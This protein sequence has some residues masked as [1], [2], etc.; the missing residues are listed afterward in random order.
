[1]ARL[2]ESL[3]QLEAAY[4][5]GRISSRL[6]VDQARQALFN[7]Q[8]SLLSARA[9]YDTRV[10]GYK[11]DLGLPPNLPLVIQRHPARP[12]QFTDA[13][14]T[15][16]D[17]QLG[18]VQAELRNPDRIKSVA[19]LRRQLHAL[20]NLERPLNRQLKTI[21]QD[22]VRLRESVPNRQ[23]Q[24]RLLGAREDLA[25]LSIEQARVDPEA[26]IARVK[27]LEKRIS[28][29]GQELEKE[30]G[31]LHAFDPEAPGLDLE[32]ARS[33][34]SEIASDLSG[35]LLALSLD[36]TA[37]RLETATLPPI[38]LTEEE[39]LAIAKEN[40][41]DLMNA[42]ARLVDAWR[43]VDYHANPLNSAVDLVADGNLNTIGDSST[44]LDGRTG[45]L[46][47]ACVSIPRSTASPSGTT[48]AKPS[49]RI[50]TPA[51]TICSLR[52]AS[53]RAC[54]TPCAS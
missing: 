44:R 34:L 30:V 5:A 18:T 32:T 16:L 1:V 33:K 26:L 48:T 19:D 28:H 29:V 23:E 52:I 27:Q 49:S 38:A 51:A 45:F 17:G 3:D 40:R 47:M 6:Q 4:D 25:D 11:V 39:A 53:C 15:V 31:G 41:L 8:S 24:L 14:A 12:L 10:D 36:Q 35:M 2:R 13:A 43:L 50:S 9:A 22:I 54:A 7:G 42:R 20:R 46:R 37:T 21:Q